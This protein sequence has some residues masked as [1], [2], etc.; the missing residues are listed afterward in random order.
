MIPWIGIRRDAHIYRKL[1]FLD[2]QQGKG[3]VHAFMRIFPLR[4]AQSL[5][6]AKGFLFGQRKIFY[7][8]VW[9]LWLPMKIS[10][11]LWQCLED[12]LPIG[13]WRIK[14]NCSKT[15]SLCPVYVIEMQS[16]AFYECP[17]V[18]RV[19]VVFGKL[20]EELASL[21]LSRLGNNSHVG[22]R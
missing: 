7:V 3:I 9:H 4:N 1:I 5:S 20:H 19:W 6:S 22:T 12:G 14:V 2:I 13:E 15:C 10:S 8:E 11:S 17:S 16:H 18:N 21:V